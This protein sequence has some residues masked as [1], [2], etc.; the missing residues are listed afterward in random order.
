MTGPAAVI[1]PI[2]AFFSEFL[3]VLAAATLVALTFERLRLPVVLG[4][5]AAGALIGPG[6]LGLLH[7][8]ET[9]HHLA[10]LGMVLLMLTIGLEFSFTRLKGLMRIAFVGGPA[11]ILL[12][13]AVAMVFAR[14][15][16]WTPYQGFLLGAVVALSSTAIVLKY[17]MDRAELDTQ[18]GRIA[19]AILV[20][21]DIA[22]APL[23]VLVLAFSRSDAPLGGT[24][25]NSV[26]RAALLLA[27]VF[28]L[29]RFILPRPLR[30]IATGKSREIFLLAALL[31]S[32]GLALLSARLGLSMALGAFF[33]GLIFANTDYGHH[34]AGEIAPF[35][36]IFVSLFFVSIGSLFD[37]GFLMR[38]LGLVLPV[39]ALILATN[40]VIVTSVVLAFGYPPRVALMTG[41]ILA[42]IGEFSFLLLEAARGT[43]A[44]GALFYQTVLSSSVLTIFLTPLLFLGV[45]MLVRLTE[46]L[47]FF[48]TPP[49][50]PAKGAEKALSGHV[51]LCGF[52]RA[53]R[54][55]ALVFDEEKVP[56]IVLD[57]N[58][59]NIRDA[60]AAG[61]EALYGDAVSRD[62]LVKAGIG[63]AKALVVSFGDTT[64]QAEIIRLVQ[65][66]N[67]GIFLVVRTRFEKNV[68]WLYELGADVV[69]ME[70]LEVSLELTRVI[71]EHF[72]VPKERSAIYRHKI[73][74][75]KELAIEQSIFKRA[76]R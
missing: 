8:L 65:T 19:V 73:R 16:G 48:G 17:L 32:F 30:W 66:L 10:E 36:H 67:P 41:M 43:E 42:Q 53:G 27:A 62:A 9:I 29:A 45:P 23:L 31:I 52:G 34:I 13:I 56:F 71:L 11:Q 55:L 40:C 76:M 51:I 46:R 18:H 57:M 49:V 68:S 50:G 37:A 20:F 69:V 58:P 75:R 39:T 33:A 7:D 12:T 1:P 15:L 74:A 72:E 4:F 25:A 28:A 2:P 21:Q 64:G 24:L 44:V 47:P 6:G 63:R 14:V 35:R 5:L 22:V 26:F 70:E 38:N 60:R 61:A 54:D 3:I 59:G